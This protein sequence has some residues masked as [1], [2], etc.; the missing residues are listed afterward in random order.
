[1]TLVL[2]IVC[3]GILGVGAVG[4]VLTW[5]DRLY[6]PGY[7]GICVPITFDE[8]IQI[9]T[10]HARDD[11]GKELLQF[12][13]SDIYFYTDPHTPVPLAFESVVDIYKYKKWCR[14]Y[15]KLEYSFENR[16]AKRKISRLLQSE[17]SQK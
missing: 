4:I 9:Y 15:K 7:H 3:G 17:E 8:F 10:R 11:R 6:H 16:L 5:F 14:N 1:M 2:L 13:E 12:D